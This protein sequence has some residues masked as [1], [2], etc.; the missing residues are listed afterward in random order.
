MGLSP[1]QAPDV[2]EL[3]KLLDTALLSLHHCI[4]GTYELPAIALSLLVISVLVHFVR[5]R[6]TERRVHSLRV[7]ELE[8]QLRAVTQQLDETKSRLDRLQLV[9]PLTELSNRRGMEL[10]LSREVNRAQ[11]N[12]SQI[13]AILLNCDDFKRIN[14]TLGHAVGDVALKEMVER[15]TTTLRP[16]DYVARIGGDE[17]VILLTDTQFAEAKL[18]AERIRLSVAE[19]PIRNSN[20]TIFMT[21]SLGVAILPYEI[22]SVEELLSLTRHALRESKTSGK[23]RV[24][25]GLVAA[26]RNGQGDQPG[27]QDIVEVLRNGECFRCAKHPIIRLS[28]EVQLGYELLIRGPAG[29]FQMPY[30][31]FR[32]AIENNILTRVDLRCMKTCISAAQYLERGSRFDVNLFP[33]TIIDTPIDKLIEMFPVDKD[34]G[35]FCVEISEQQFIG[36][37]SYLKEH[38][39]ALKKSGVQVAI[40]DVGFGRSSLESLILLEPDI[41]KVDIKYVAGIAMDK[42]KQRLMRRLIGVVASLGAELIA[43]GV[44]TRDDLEV[45]KEMGV[46]YAQGYLWGYPMEVK[47]PETAISLE[48]NKK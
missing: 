38:T 20:D 40:D 37:P 29:P 5:K 35:Q 2:T 27:A 16:S 31:F 45:I 7:A 13:V 41:V 26:T 44:E 18:I 34:L 32:I 19:S 28:D 48:S 14:D 24:T 47:T 15:I 39:A 1:R 21:A 12:G 17:F 8:E 23:N 10:V 4:V 43:E 25:E 11:R 46:E 42:Q 3:I 6:R 33:S 22:S 30:D 36:D 9:D